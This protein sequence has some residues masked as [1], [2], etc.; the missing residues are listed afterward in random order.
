MTEIRPRHRRRLTAPAA[1]AVCTA[2]V[3]TSALLTQATASP[4]EQV[5]VGAGSYT[6]ELPPGASG[7]SDVTG[8]PVTPKVTPDFDQPVTTNEWW[9][10]LIFQRY[11]DNP[12]GENLHAHPMTFKAQASGMEIG[13]SPTHQIVGEANKYEY[14]HSA[15]LVLGVEGLNAPSARVAGYGDWTVTAELADGTR[16]LRTTIGQGLPFAYADVSGAAATAQFTSAP[17]VWHDD[18]AIVGVTVGDS[19]YALFAPSS[20]SWQHS[21]STFTAAGAEYVSVALLPEPADLATFAPYAHSFVTGSELTYD[22]DPEAATLTS[23]YAVTTEAREGSQTGTLLALY[24]HHWKE[25]T[26]ELTDLR[27]ASPRGPMRV[28]DGDRFVT[29]LTTQ[30]ILPSLPTVDEADHDRLRSMIDAEINA[31]DPWKG[32]VDTYWTGKA[33]GRL[34]QLVP[35]ADSIGYTAGRDA[36]LDLLKSRLENWLTADGAGDDAQFYYDATWDTLIGYPSSF[37]ADQELN[38]H[39]F[40][41]GYFVTAAATIA[42]YDRSWIADEQWGDMITTVLTD[43]NN[44]DRDD[45][46]FPWLRSFSAYAGHGWASGHAGFAAG[47]N[48][49]SSSEAMHFAASTAV[50]GSIMGNEQ[51]RDLGV[52]MHTTQASAMSRY[53]QNSDGD[54]FPDAFAHDVVGMVWGDG[55]DYRIWWD[56]TDEEHYGINYLPITAGSLYLGYDPAHAAAMYAS[57]V[58][59][60]GRE[61]ETWREIHWAQRALSDGDA[62]LAAFEAQWQSYEPES[63]SSK[64]HTYQWV[65]TLAALGQVDTSVTADS[66]HY[67]VFADGGERT[68]V[69]FNPGTAPRTV[70]FSDGV[71]L[72]VEPGQLA[73]S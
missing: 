7:P 60:L 36:L 10:S 59:R 5:P 63:G 68:H 53:W 70:T 62:A 52:Y 18:G 32:A 41:Y 38:D 50:L 54:A 55:G 57:L 44:P 42:R 13:H 6:T 51:I 48:Q 64:A 73:T 47:N 37:G 12:Y 31:D 17:Q 65:S 29:E 30:G 28:V 8:A 11:P 33:L 21:G 15:D 22:Y 45:Q 19:H 3:G 67:A 4:A 2:L 14:G 16:T 58:D 40:H 69:A 27:Y 49:E 9:S 25:T 71:S 56:G 23:T 34:A 72:T 66:A 26:T 39:D 20:I 1:V 43:A 24:P 61:P 35:I 46:R